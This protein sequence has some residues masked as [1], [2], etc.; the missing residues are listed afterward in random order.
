MTRKRLGH[1]RLAGEL[2]GLVRGNQSGSSPSPIVRPSPVIRKQ[3]RCRPNEQ[4]GDAARCGERGEDGVTVEFSRVFRPPPENAAYGRRGPFAEVPGRH[5]A[6]H[7]RELMAVP[8][9]LQA[10]DS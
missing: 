3:R 2:G 8:R 9:R 7:G 4:H 1:S 5:R 10:Q 6:H